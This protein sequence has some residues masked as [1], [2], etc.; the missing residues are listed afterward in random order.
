MKTS[1]DIQKLFH[2]YWYPNCIRGLSP[3][4]LPK[5]FSNREG[6]KTAF[7]KHISPEWSLSVFKDLSNQVIDY[8]NFQIP[9]S[10]FSLETGQMKSALI[11]KS[12]IIAKDY[13]S[14]LP[15]CSAAINESFNMN[16]EVL[17]I[18]QLPPCNPT[19]NLAN[20][21]INPTAVYIEDIIN[22]LPER[23]S[24]SGVIP[25][26]RAGSDNI[27][28]YYSIGRWA[29]RLL[30]ILAIGF[31]III[32][33]LLQ[34]EKKVMLRWVGRLLVFTSGFGIISLVV[35]LIGFD[36]FVVMLI[37]GISIIS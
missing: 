23:A 15:R 1:P 32:A 3:A 14:T 29:L 20:V 18:G 31:L 30:P 24:L 34:A 9:T 22:R 12:E 17:D 21:F 26:E 7:Q 2:K 33:L 5:I 16:I 27:F 10:T 37:T 28:Y 36:Q 13:L 25:F 35:L 11:L 8:L 4:Q 19:E 6:L